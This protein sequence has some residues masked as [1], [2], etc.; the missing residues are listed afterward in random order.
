MLDRRQSDLGQIEHLPRP[1]PDIDAIPKI[2]MTPTADPG[3]VIDDHIGR[4]DLSQ[5]PT[6]MAGLPTPLAA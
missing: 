5:M 3:N 1:M 4:R 6:A 2:T